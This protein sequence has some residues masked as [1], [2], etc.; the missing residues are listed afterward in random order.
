MA[1]WV[2][3]LFTCFQI[4]CHKWMICRSRINKGALDPSMPR[5][6]WVASCT[7]AERQTGICGP[8]S[9]SYIIESE[10]AGILGQLIP[11]NPAKRLTLIPQNVFRTLQIGKPKSSTAWERPLARL[12]RPF[13]SWV[14]LR[15]KL[16]C[17]P[18]DLPQLVIGSPQKQAVEVSVAEISEGICDEAIGFLT[19]RCPT[20]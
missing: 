13:R 3:L 16:L 10:A 4:S 1:F 20:K 2:I 9:T 19:A 11:T 14:R 18:H 17:R 7:N 15:V 8:Q 12:R 6:A 5:P